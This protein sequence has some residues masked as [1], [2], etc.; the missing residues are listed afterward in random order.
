MTSNLPQLI[1]ESIS[2]EQALEIKNQFE[3]IGA[4][5]KIS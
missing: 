1:K 2:K 5:I 4:Q 3:E